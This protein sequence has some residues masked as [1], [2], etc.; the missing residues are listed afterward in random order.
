MAQ[1]NFC[2]GKSVNSVGESEISLRLYVSRDVR[3]RIGSDIW[4]DRKR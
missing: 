1:T 4:V 3:I 2:I